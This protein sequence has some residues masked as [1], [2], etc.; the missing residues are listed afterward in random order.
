MI[1]AGVAIVVAGYFLFHRDFDT[2]FVIA[3]AGAV[4]W[5]LNYRVQMKQITAAADLAENKNEQEEDIDG[6]SNTQ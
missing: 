6:D 4:A 5:F 1:I 2:A 3:A